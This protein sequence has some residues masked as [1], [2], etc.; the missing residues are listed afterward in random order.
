MCDDYAGTF[1]HLFRTL[2][3]KE[4]SVTEVACQAQGATCCRFHVAGR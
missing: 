2:V 3:A 1:E 4:I